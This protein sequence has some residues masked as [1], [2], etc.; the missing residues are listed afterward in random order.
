MGF[1]MQ[2][3]YHS[4]ED[5]HGHALMASCPREKDVLDP[6]A[7][8]KPCPTSNVQRAD[9]RS[10]MESCSRL[11]L[12]GEITPVMAWSMIWGH[13]RLN[14]LTPRDFGILKGDLGMKVR[15]YGFGAVLEEFEVRDALSNVLATKIESYTGFQ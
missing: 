12:D 11:E 15:C 7:V 6:Q 10:L 1:L 14:E 2:R 4:D 5:V 13:P 3:S 8:L 9:L